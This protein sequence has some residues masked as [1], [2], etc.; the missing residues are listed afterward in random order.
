MDPFYLLAHCF[1][2]KH[3]GPLELESKE[4]F[5]LN[6]SEPNVRFRPVADFNRVTDFVKQ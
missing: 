1:P 4:Y 3:R 2:S 5:L 6:F